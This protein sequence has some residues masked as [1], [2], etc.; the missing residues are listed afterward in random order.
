VVERWRGGEEGR[1]EEEVEEGR[2]RRGE[3]NER[4]NEDEKN[5]VEFFCFPV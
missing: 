4:T 1:E 3:M 5:D 2:R